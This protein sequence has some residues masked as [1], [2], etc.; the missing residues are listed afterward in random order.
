ML[1][2]FLV[3]LGQ[4]MKD[5]GLAVTIDQFCDA[6][7]Y[8]LLASSLAPDPGIC[9]SLLPILVSKVEDEPAYLRA[10]KRFEQCYTQNKDVMYDIVRGSS[11]SFAA[12]ETGSPDKLNWHPWQQYLAYQSGKVE[13]MQFEDSILQALNRGEE[14]K[15]WEQ[16]LEQKLTELFVR[17]V[18]TSTGNELLQ[19]ALQFRKKFAQSKRNWNKVM[20]V[21]PEHDPRKTETT[22][23]VGRKKQLRPEFI[24]GYRPNVSRWGNNELFNRPMENINESDS[25]KLQAPIRDMAQRLRVRLQGMR[26]K[27]NG[28]IDMRKT[29]HAAYQTFGEPMRIFHLHPKRKPPKWIVLSDVSGSV[30]H[31]TR[32]FMSFLYELRQ[33]MAEDVRGFVFVSKVQ[34]ITSILKEREYS[35]MVRRIYSEGEID[36]R[37]YS[38]YGI[39]FE[40]FA[41]LIDD[42]LDNQTV[43]LIIGDARNN[44]REPRLDI[45]NRWTIKTRKIVWFNPDLPEKWNQGDSIIDLYTRVINHVYD[46]STPAKLVMAIEKIVA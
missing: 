37:G 36:F 22:P 28:K 9:D 29:L 24:L 7:K 21:L 46:V 38:D 45:L 40:Q 14:I 20:S 8:M 41:S 42:V 44:K 6:G 23:K 13:R 31:A 17:G 43:L 30:K 16:A 25:L 18:E 11:A 1:I 15:T 27:E 2:N 32:I 5:E 10:W 3:K 12:M 35:N 4:A 19:N 39:A 34:E 33:V 26:R